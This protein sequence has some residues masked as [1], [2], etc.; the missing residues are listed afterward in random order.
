MSIVL[1]M[2][3]A[4]CDANHRILRLGPCVVLTI[5]SSK[6]SAK[7][8]SICVKILIQ[9][10]IDKPPKTGGVTFQSG[11]YVE[12]VRRTIPAFVPDIIHSTQAKHMTWR[13]GTVV[14]A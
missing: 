4:S 6:F 3:L 5:L 7:Q 10:G 2:I 1:E 14:R 13:N 12:P 9:I 11:E 8:I